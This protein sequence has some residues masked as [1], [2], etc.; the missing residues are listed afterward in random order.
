M[1]YAHICKFGRTRFAKDLEKRCE[2]AE[3]VES[4]KTEVTC[5]LQ[6]RKKV[7]KIAGTRTVTA[8]GT[9]DKLVVGQDLV[10][11]EHSEREGKLA[12]LYRVLP[13]NSRVA[14]ARK[15]PEIQDLRISS[16]LSPSPGDPFDQK[17]I[18]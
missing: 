15:V 2:S 13:E 18:R 6:E 5:A 14:L 3:F 17:E 8:T 7:Y 12:H 9:E 11:P 16:V 1:V 10:A 4:L